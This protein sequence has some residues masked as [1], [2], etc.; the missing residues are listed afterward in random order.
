VEPDFTIHF[1]QKYEKPVNSM[2]CGLL[3]FNKLIILFNSWQKRLHNGCMDC[4]L[5]LGC[6]ASRALPS[7]ASGP[8]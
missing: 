7:G 4:M 3:L 5:R 1:I 8:V 6:K 2:V